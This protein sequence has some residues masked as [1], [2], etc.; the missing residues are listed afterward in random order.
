[1]LIRNE[2]WDEDW[3]AP[4]D[5]SHLEKQEGLTAA[6]LEVVADHVVEILNGL[7]E[8]WPVCPEHGK[9]LT[10]CSGTWNCDGIPAHGFEVGA[11]GL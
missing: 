5:A 11:L 8:R 4:S 6:A 1:V 10:S 7:G 2:V 3:F 9:L